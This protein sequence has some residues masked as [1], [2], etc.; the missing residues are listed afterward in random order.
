MRAR[1]FVLMPGG[2]EAMAPGMYS[3]PLIHWS[4]RKL[5]LPDPSE[6]RVPVAA[7]LD[8]NAKGAP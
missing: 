1:G 8:E 2:F 4:A 6:S 7:C 3:S 5:R